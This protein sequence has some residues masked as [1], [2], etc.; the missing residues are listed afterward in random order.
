MKS[1]NEDVCY[2]PLSTYCRMPFLNYVNKPK[3]HFDRNF[4][5]HYK[6]LLEYLYDWGRQE[7]MDPGRNDTIVLASLSKNLYIGSVHFTS[8]CNP[9]TSHAD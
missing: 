4:I 8:V 2:L 6:Y 1:G 9:T 5:Y 7:R 3:A